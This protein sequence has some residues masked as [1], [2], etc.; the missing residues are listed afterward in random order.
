MSKTILIRN[1][2]LATLVG[3]GLG[4]VADGAVRIEHGKIT[5]AGPDAE[6]QTGE[7]PIEELDAEGRWLL[8]GLV[9]CHT[10]LVWGGSRAEEFERRVAG[11]TYEQINREG[12]GIRSTVTATREATE[13]EL[14]QAARRRL[15]AMVREG[16]RTVEIKS[17]Y[18]LDRETE[19]KCLRAARRLGEDTGVTVRTTYLGLHVNPP[20]FE[21]RADEYVDYVNEQVMPA[22][23]RARLANA[24]DAFCETIAF[25]ADQV[26]R[27][28]EAAKRLG[29]PVKLH[30]DQLSDS[31]GA[32]LAAEYGALSADHVEYA[33]PEGVRAMAQAGTVAV[34]LPG[35][36][37]SLDEKQVPPIRAFR[38]HG[39]PMAV[40]TDANPGTSPCTSLLLMLNM[41]CT[42][43]R[44]SPTEA[45]RG[46]TREAARA[47]GLEAHKG[48]IARGLDGD[49]TLW[50]IDHPRDLCYMIGPTVTPDLV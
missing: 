21:G 15:D 16:V 42:L 33:N 36:F 38:E 32:R 6:L 47:L 25:S 11:E 45:L 13:L 49:L 26:R 5:W 2:H 37:Y 18:G 7:E 29:L 23:A 17:G 48:M 31:G 50:P 4:E 28:F 41:A 20:E 9:D 34:L 27:Y 19:L 43:F 30:A 39:V 24:V 3:D 40:A 10:H 22:V 46:A 12:G 35:A 1:A 14:V 8:P 44:L